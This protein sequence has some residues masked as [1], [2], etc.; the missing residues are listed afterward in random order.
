MKI[1]YII[2]RSLLGAMLL[3]AS[4]T[5]FYMVATNKMQMPTGQPKVYMDGISTVHIMDIVKVIE[6][7]CGLAFI[8]GFFNKL[9]AIVIFPI[10]INI[11]LFHAFLEPAELPMMIVLLLFD[12]YIAYYYR[13]TY[14]ALFAAK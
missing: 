9:A 14:K 8:T 5:Y 6:L 12:L 7:L 1:A 11:V 10:L 3:F 2:I 4:I 13:E